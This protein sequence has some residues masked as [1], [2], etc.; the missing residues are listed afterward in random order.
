LSFD[1]IMIELIKPYSK[2]LTSSIFKLTFK[3]VFSNW[4]VLLINIKMNYNGLPVKFC[5]CLYIINVTFKVLSSV[6]N[7]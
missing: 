5:A 6:I 1:S 4:C 2:G 7:V 3:I